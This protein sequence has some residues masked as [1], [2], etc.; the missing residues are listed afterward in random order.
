MISFNFVECMAE[1]YP[2][3]QFEHYVLSPNFESI[4]ND[5]DAFVEEIFYLEMVQILLLFIRATLGNNWELHLSAVR[6]MLPWFFITDPVNYARYGSIYW[7]EMITI[8]STH[9][10]ICF[11]VV[12]MT[13]VVKVVMI[14]VL[15]NSSLFFD[16][17]PGNQ[18]RVLDIDK[19]HR[20]LGARLCDA[21]IG[22]HAFTGICKLRALH[23]I[24]CI[25]WF[26]H[27][28]KRQ[29]LCYIYS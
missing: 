22:Y 13:N 29:E 26:L 14:T 2:D 5:F 4:Q 17:G 20:Q 25:N 7:L 10:G 23:K 11:I 21:L 27:I 28:L 3:E 8:N 19:I 9:P 18:W 15:F 12:Q 24:S 1:A 16:T 6:S